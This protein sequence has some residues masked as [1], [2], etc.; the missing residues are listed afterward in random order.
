M[1]AS[2]CRP[3][4]RYNMRKKTVGQLKLTITNLPEI[5]GRKMAGQSPDVQFFKDMLDEH[6]AELA[7]RE[8][9]CS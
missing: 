9:K 3:K 1:S 8:A 5:I 4:P 2:G 6:K 7:R